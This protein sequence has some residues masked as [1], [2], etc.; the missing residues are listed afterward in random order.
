MPMGQYQNGNLGS[1]G[2]IGKYTV[3]LVCAVERR[4]NVLLCSRAKHVNTL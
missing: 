2:E 3:K 4:G 1:A